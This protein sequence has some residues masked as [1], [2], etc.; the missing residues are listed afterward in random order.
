AISHFA[1]CGGRAAHIIFVRLPEGRGATRSY[2]NGLTPGD[3]KQFPAGTRVAMVR[4][5]FAID[6]AAKI[7]TTPLVDSVQ[8]R[9]YGRIP[10]D[11]IANFHGDY[12][13][14]DVYEFALDRC[15]LFARQHGL[16]AFGANDTAEPFER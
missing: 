15:K 6:R 1:M 8:I 4:R 12:G 16:R 9:V 11:P 7:R 2:L 10:T 13:E 14:Q 5:A 3:V